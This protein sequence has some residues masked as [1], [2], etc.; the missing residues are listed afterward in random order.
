MPSDTKSRAC[1]RDHAADAGRIGRVVLREDGE[2]VLAV[3]EFAQYRLDQQAGRA[4]ALRDDD[5]AIRQRVHAGRLFRSCGA[6]RRNG[7][8]AAG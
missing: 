3:G 4:F 2:R 5:Q 7:T 6:Q 8:N 1:R